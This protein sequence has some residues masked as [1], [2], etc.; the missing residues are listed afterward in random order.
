MPHTRIAIVGAGFAGLGAAIRLRQEGLDDFVVFEKNGDVGGTWWDNT[1]PGCQCDVPSHL[2]SFSFALNPEWSNTYSA[3]PEIRAY[4]RRTAEHFGVLPHIR[5]GTA[6]L[7]A[8]WDGEHTAWRLETSDGVY[9]ADVLIGANG[10]L[11]EPSTPDIPGLDRFGGRA[12]HSARWEDTESLVGKRVAVIGTGASAIQIVPSIQ[13]DVAQLH[14]FQRTPPWVLPHSGRPVSDTERALYRRIPTAQRF[15]RGLVY[16]SRELVAYGMTRNPRMLQPVRRLALRH[17]RDQV[18]DPALRAKLRPSYTPGCKRLLPSNDYYPALAQENVEVVTDGI[19]E[20]RERSIVTS[21]GAE[22][23]VDVIV[24][25][26]GFHVT[27]NPM[28]QR[29]RGRDGRSLLE[30]WQIHGAQA[31]LGTTVPGYPNFFLLAGPN[32]GIGHTSLVFMIE[33]QITY[34]IGAL[35]AIDRRRAATVEVHHE[36]FA[37][38][39]EDLQARMRRTVWNTGGCAS[40][41]LDAEG[42]NTT[43]W[44]DFTWRFRQRTRRFDAEHYEFGA[45]GVPVAVPTERPTAVEVA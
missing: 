26:T 36:P 28:M 2:Y 19:T 35:R 20:I 16:W 4:L 45:P 7:D 6:V 8:C 43:L 15:V 24:L 31:Y 17:L 5:L 21:D 41:Y 11:S 44:P 42:R 22:R 3:Q 34:V 25:A 18:K 12:F 40:W 37:A 32:T 33:S 30:H 38:Y 39:N 23:Q 13:P 29:I 9:T 10:A 14:L 1:Y 27:D